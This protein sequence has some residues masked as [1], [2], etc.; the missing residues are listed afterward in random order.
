M[1]VF[2]EGQGLRCDQ[3]VL[4]NSNLNQGKNVKKMFEVGILYF[5]TATRRM[6]F[7]TREVITLTFCLES[8]IV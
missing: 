2:G 8:L 4:V 3:L 5:I 7:A 6:M 1:W